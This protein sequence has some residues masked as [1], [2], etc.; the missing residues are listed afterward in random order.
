VTLPPRSIVWQPADGRSVPTSGRGARTRTAILQAAV[1]VFGKR[2][3]SQTTM[4]DVAQDAGVAAGTVYQYF[5]DKTDV[6]RCLLAELEDRLYRET[7][8]PTG[9]DGRLVVGENVM[10][11]LD[12]YRE[13][14]AIYGAWWE[15]IEPP[16][17]FTEA[18]VA[19]H[20]RFRADWVKLIERGQDDG[21]ISHGI[22]P[23]IGADLIV[24]MFERP[25]HSRIVMQWDAEVDD[26]EIADVMA[27]LLG[28]GLLRP[29][30]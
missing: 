22:D 18:W 20:D 3:F 24:A 27:D 25:T 30:A 11:Y 17:E 14:A 28:R 19:I 16:T 1:R 29:A 2:G 12:V 5:A 15:Q 21:L 9:E 10:R 6:L 26:A 8:I 23:A 7:R 4:L 13:H